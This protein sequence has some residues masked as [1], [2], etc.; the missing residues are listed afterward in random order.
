MYLSHFHLNLKP[1][2]I[3]TDQRFLYLS[4]KHKE[5]L[6]ILHYGIMDN[7]GVLV[8]TGDVG[9]GKTLLVHTL[10]GTLGPEVKTAV[11][12]DPSLRGLDFF[13]YMAHAFGM[14][15]EFNTKG[16]FLISFGEFLDSRFAANQQALLVIDEAQYVDPVQLEEI[17]ILS[18]LERENFKR[19][20]IFL[21][22]QSEFNSII[23]DSRLRALKQRITTHFHIDP[24]TLKE[25]G[26]YVRH[27]L[28]V[29]GCDRPLFTTSALKKIFGFTRGYPRLIN[30][31]CDH[32]LLS[33][34]VK[35]L[36]Q[37]DPA[38]V[39]ECA[40]DLMHPSQLNEEI[41]IHSANQPRIVKP[42]DADPP[43]AAAPK[44]LPGVRTR[45]IEN[46]ESAERPNPFVLLLQTFFRKPAY[47][48]AMAVFIPAFVW[49]TF[50]DTPYTDR[51]A[52]SLSP[53]NHQGSQ[54]QAGGNPFPSSVPYKHLGVAPVDH[55]QKQSPAD[56]IHEI[57]NQQ[58]E[59]NTAAVP[60]D[61]S[62][63]PMV[64]LP[65]VR[66]EKNAAPPMASSQAAPPIEL[67][68]ADD[69]EDVAQPADPH[70]PASSSSPPDKRPSKSIT[71]PPVINETDAPP[72]RY[73]KKGGT[74]PVAAEVTTTL[75]A[76]ASTPA[77][78]S[79]KI[80]PDQAAQLDVVDTL[81]PSRSEIDSS[82]IL[83]V[84]QPQEPSVMPLSTTALTEPDAGVP[85]F[86]IIDT[87][88]SAI[89]DFVIR[90]RTEQSS[91]Q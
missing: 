68:A 15:T 1:F 87:D 79:G 73:E 32:C 64:V 33:A 62:A 49:F 42:P 30:I 27:R 50:W 11:I 28:E 46:V 48:L 24:L 65:T 59:T 75:P 78:A 20:N 2:Q 86:P 90:K 31:I 7:R 74:E 69:L 66:S 17:R 5:A 85:Q 91:N 10:V 3:T 19:I 57:S 4:E 18:D 34:F 43:T 22:G 55:V 40:A 44:T 60:A 56:S 88:P 12:N 26:L 89:I 72:V 82:V 77:A 35:G 9:T 84:E 53:K 71:E 52:S 16:E 14:E 21:V 51:Q 13:N 61:Q 81:S 41:P 80:K 38:L 25:T 45:T 83:D 39:K 36:H 37:V 6:A 70:S 54:T 58:Q 63:L 8:L 47:L 67:P 23:A 76:A 29:A